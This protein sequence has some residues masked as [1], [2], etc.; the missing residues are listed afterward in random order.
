MNTVVQD[1][2][3]FSSFRDHVKHFTTGRPSVALIIKTLFRDIEQSREQSGRSVRT[4]ECVQSLGMTDYVEN[5]QFD[6]EECITY[7]IKLFCPRTE[8]INHPN[9]NKVPENCLFCIDGGEYALCFNCN[10]QSNKLYRT[11][12]CQ[13]EFPEPDVRSSVLL[14]MKTMTMDEYGHVMDETYQ[15]IHCHPVRTPSILEPNYDEC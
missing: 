9:H 8:K 7:V 5:S 2:L 10:K 3:S 13:F 15:F 1:L 6:D 4:H 14:K 12:L 11:A